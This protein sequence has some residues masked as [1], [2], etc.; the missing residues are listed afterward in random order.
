MKKLILTEGTEFEQNGKDLAIIDTDQRGGKPIMLDSSDLDASII[1]GETQALDRISV[2]VSNEPQIEVVATTEDQTITPGDEYT[3]LSSVVVKGVTSDIDSDIQPENIL[4]GV[5]ILGTTGTATTGAYILVDGGLSSGYNSDANKATIRKILEDIESGDYPIVYLYSRYSGGGSFNASGPNR[6]YMCNIDKSNT[7]GIMFKAYIGVCS[8]GGVQTKNNIAYYPEEW[9]WV[10]CPITEG[11]PGTITNGVNTEYA[12]H[13]NQWTDSSPVAYNNTTEFTPTSD[14]NLANK[15]YVDDS[16]GAIDVPDITPYETYSSNIGRFPIFNWQPNIVMSGS[17]SSLGS[18]DLNLLRGYIQDMYNK[19]KADFAI[20]CALKDDNGTGNYYVPHRFLLLQRHT[21]AI[22][23]KPTSMQFVGFSIYDQSFNATMA[24]TLLSLTLSWSGD[25]VTVSSGYIT[26]YR[27]EYVVKSDLSTYA[28]KTYVDTA[29]S[30]V[31]SPPVYALDITSAYNTSSS[32]NYFNSTDK[33]AFQAIIQD[34]YNKGLNSLVLFI[35]QKRG[36]N[37]GASEQHQGYLLTMVSDKYIK[38]KPT[39]VDFAGFGNQNITL[40]DTY[41]SKLHLY[42]VLSWTDNTCTVSQVGYRNIE[43]RYL[44]TTSAN[45]AYTP[46]SDNDPATKGYVDTAV[47]GVGGG[48]GAG[49]DYLYVDCSG[50]TLNNTY[51][52]DAQYIAYDIPTA[53]KNKLVSEYNALIDASV[54]IHNIVIVCQNLPKWE[55]RSFTFFGG[56]LELYPNLATDNTYGNRVYN[57]VSR[58]ITNVMQNIWKNTL[59]P[60]YIQY[61]I[62]LFADDS[63]EDYKADSVQ[64][65]LHGWLFD[66]S[67]IFMTED[68]GDTRYLSKNNTSS[69]SPSGD[70]NPATKKYV[71]D[72]VAG[73]GGGGSSMTEITFTASQVVSQDPII[74]LLTQSQYDLIEDSDVMLYKVNAPELNIP[75]ILLYKTTEDENYITLTMNQ[76]GWG[77]SADAPNVHNTN[78]LLFVLYGK[79][80]HKIRVCTQQSSESSVPTEYYHLTNKRYVD[81]AIASAGGGVPT[82]S[83]SNTTFDFGAESGGQ[84]DSD[85]LTLIKNFVTSNNIATDGSETPLYISI[86]GNNVWASKLFPG[87]IAISDGATK[88]LA[89]KAIAFSGAYAYVFSVQVQ[90]SSDIASPSYQGWSSY[91]LASGTVVSEMDDKLQVSDLD[92]NYFSIDDNLSYHEEL[93]ICTVDNC[94]ICDHTGEINLNFTIANSGSDN[95]DGLCL[96]GTF[97]DSEDTPQIIQLLP[98]IRAGETVLIS[99]RYKIDSY[100][101]ENHGLESLIITETE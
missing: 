82:L 77:G 53:V 38:N 41:F 92:S 68:T 94:N 33:D 96:I 85:D 18:S 1:N 65:W 50:L 89:I 55:S 19:G 80:D 74:V 66:N 6:Y 90:Y 44:S 70:Y 11:E 62:G 37:T 49:Y 24:H 73:A 97:L 101:W 34:A 93:E 36:T 51:G 63:H 22:Y 13:Y 52:G 8:T 58:P 31:N 57:F 9:I 17:G 59:Q 79:A 28:T 75:D 43:S 98:T 42:A 91:E 20:Y 48:A 21:K 16:I 69:F 25:T 99:G 67:K 32:V 4:R 60:T 7:N 76:P 15:K 64:E 10:Y 95:R 47:A 30:G 56:T 45:P 5:N 26:A 35:A 78:T 86:P 2:D 3:G 81:N 84:L 71:D 87:T 83:L 23:A 46:V 88:I 29:V 40:T 61:Q 54:D 39:Q 14:Y 27:R 12:I 100:D 72:A